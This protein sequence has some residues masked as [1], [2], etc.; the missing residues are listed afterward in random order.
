MVNP[1]APLPDE[2]ILEICEHLITVDAWE[3]RFHLGTAHVATST[4]AALALSCRYL[5]GFGMRYLYHTYQARI[6]RPNSGFLR[7]I[8]WH[9]ELAS[10]VRE[11]SIDDPNISARPLGSCHVRLSM[12][13]EHLET[14]IRKLSLP[15][16][17]KWISLLPREPQAVDLAVLIFKCRHSIRWLDIPTRESDIDPSSPFHDLQWFH[18][19]H[20]ASRQLSKPSAVD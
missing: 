12:S 18:P 7:A 19:L 13:A 15:Y 1:L 2:L 5:H 17:D 8:H 4:F 10:N 9:P 16:Q 11:I 14:E 3:R 20:H 6:H